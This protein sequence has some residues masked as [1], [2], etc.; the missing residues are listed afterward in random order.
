VSLTITQDH[1]MRRQLYRPVPPGL[2]RRSFRYVYRHRRH[3]VLR[4]ASCHPELLRKVRWL[5][6]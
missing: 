4:H 1:W 5:Q 2:E 6:L 3:L